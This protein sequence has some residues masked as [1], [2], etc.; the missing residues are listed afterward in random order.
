MANLKTILCEKPSQALAISKMFGLSRS[1]KQATHYYNS[2]KGICV[3]N[4]FGHLFELAEPHHYDA[5]L[6]NSW[7]ISKLP[8]V[9]PSLDAFQIQLKPD[10]K[11]HFSDMK[12]RLK[13]TTTLLIATDPDDEG[14][15][16]G[17]DIVEMS[18]YQGEIKRVLASSTVKKDLED[19]FANPR[20]IEETAICADR[21]DLRRKIDWLIGINGTRAATS[22]LKS[23]KKLTRK[24]VFNVGRVVS[25]LALMVYDREQ[26][27]L[28]FKSVQHYKVEVY[29]QA[30]G[31]EFK[32]LL[33]IPEPLLKDG[34]LTNKKHAE[35]LI[36]EYL[37]KS[38]FSVDSFEKIHSKESAPLP[39]DLSSLQVDAS[40]YGITPA[41]T[42][43]LVQSLYDQPLSAVTY[44]RTDSKYLPKSMLKDIGKTLTNL[45]KV[46]PKFSD[47]KADPEKK[48]R[49]FND[50]KVTAHHA[51]VPTT[52]HVE[53]EKLTDSQKAIYILIATRYFQQFMDAFEFDK[54]KVVI[55]SGKFS[56]IAK[57]KVI[58]QKG[59][60]CLGGEK[61]KDDEL[62]NLSN[63]QSVQFLGYKLISAKT[64]PPKRF[65][66]GALVQLMG[67]PASLVRDEKFREMVEK[68]DGI[69]TPATRSDV[70]QKAISSNLII[71]QNNVA[72]PGKILSENAQFL[73]QFSVESS[74][75]MQE[76]LSSASEG[77][78][79]FSEL[80]EHFVKQ[81]IYMVQRWKKAS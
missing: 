73:E 77:N 5:D 32:A 8:V 62:P 69:G 65:T 36:N 74:V 79:S 57:G 15:L 66:E 61:L 53:L 43:Q 21:A 68:S 54:T 63:G 29:L 7:Q 45:N 13:E 34:Y 55:Q 14:E 37:P 33:D 3:L 64:S 25:A 18:G 24:K 38:G 59:W 19:G 20:P 49:C 48:A 42:L 1:D 16:I 4:A 56:F 60:K 51:I 72:K 46:V 71:I 76:K 52:K 26:Q 27:I 81:S 23:L 12:K 17:R 58:T 22:K 35:Q 2:K 75:I 44:P 6:K 11:K 80:Y 39:Y 67:N 70:I 9:P 10:F 40:K 41:K 78:M 28:N 47:F 31:V 50:S 30:D